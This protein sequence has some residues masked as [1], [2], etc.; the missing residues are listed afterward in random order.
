MTHYVAGTG[1][2]ALDVIV[3]SD[4]TIR[5]SAL[6]GS[7]GNVLSILAALGWSSCPIGVLGEDSAAMILQHDFDEVG[8]DTSFLRRSSERHTPVIY[9]HQLGPDADATHSFSFACPSC[10]VRKKPCWEGET[11]LFD[12]R[13][14]LP[15]ASVFFLDRPTPLGVALAK[16]YSEQDAIVVFEPSS[17]GDSRELFA[18]A[19]RWADIV[20][21]A[22]DR[23]NDLVEFDLQSVA[24][25]IQTLGSDGLRFRAPSIGNEWLNLGAYALPRV[26]D[27][28]GAGDWCT[29]GLIFELF[30]QKKTSP[31]NPDYNGLT[32]SLAFGQALA[33]L[34]CMTEGARGLLSAWSPAKVI[35][36]AKEL[37]SLRL[38]AFHE[39][40]LPPD[41]KVSE[42]KLDDIGNDTKLRKATP[43]LDTNN[44]L[45]CSLS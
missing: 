26:H 44:F 10:G 22:D 28:S 5:K 15:S 18:E 45:C 29:A 14:E 11:Q 42:P 1:L 2:F 32:R 12:M 30:N 35:K 20:K 38:R 16:H 21:Y 23:F 6:G 25:E 27:T 4:G 36:T 17:I 8:A 43:Q 3:S 13:H 19:L 34:N 41:S 9:Q 37:S 7:A 24:V 33:T 39:K 40:H 31:K